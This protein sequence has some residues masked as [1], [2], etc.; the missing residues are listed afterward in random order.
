[1]IILYLYYIISIVLYIVIPRV[2]QGPLVPEE[3]PGQVTSVR[4]APNVDDDIDQ[5]LLWN[6]L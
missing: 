1:M 4:V 6:Q 5:V 2:E 3:A